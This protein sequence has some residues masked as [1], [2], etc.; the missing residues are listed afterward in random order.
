[1]QLGRMKIIILP[2]P[3]ERI[4]GALRSPKLRPAGAGQPWWKVFNLSNFT[5]SESKPIIS[6]VILTK[7]ARCQDITSNLGIMS[8][9][10]QLLG[11]RLI[12]FHRDGN[13]PVAVI[14]PVFGVVGFGVRYAF[15]PGHAGIHDTLIDKCFAGGF[16]SG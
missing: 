16:G 14:H 11:C 15:D 5:L 4:P 8:G 7:S 12:P 3:E 1:M 6:N 2:N 13:A 10:G 9:P